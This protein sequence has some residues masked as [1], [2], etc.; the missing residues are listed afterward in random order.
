VRTTNNN[1]NNNDD[2]NDDDHPLV[3]RCCLTRTRTHTR[4]LSYK[5]GFVCDVCGARPGINVDRWWCD[6][7]TYDVCQACAAKESRSF[8]DL[9]DEVRASFV[10][11]RG[12]LLSVSSTRPRPQL[13]IAAHAH[14]H[15]HARAHAQLVIVRSCFVP[16]STRRC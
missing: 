13:R 1:N 15:A 4:L 16:K 8:T 12:F 9:F 7:C 6:L 3:W 10:G 14:A 2:D 11:L 5:E